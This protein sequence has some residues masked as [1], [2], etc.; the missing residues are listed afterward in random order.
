MIIVFQNQNLRFEKNEKQKNT[1]ISFWSMCGKF[2]VEINQNN[3]SKKGN[4]LAKS[5]NYHNAELGN[6][7]SK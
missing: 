1:I 5:F 4:S 7:K 2:S 6:R 3:L